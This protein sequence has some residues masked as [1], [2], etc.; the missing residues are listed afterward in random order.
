MKNILLGLM[1]LWP[2]GLEAQQYLQ[3]QTIVEDKSFEYLTTGDLDGDNDEDLIFSTV[4]GHLAWLENTG[5][6][7]FVNLT[8]LKSHLHFYF[9]PKVMDVDN[10]G[11]LDVVVTARDIR[12]I[13]FYL[14]RWMN[15]GRLGWF[16]NLDGDG[17]FGPFIPLTGMESSGFMD[18]SLVDFDVDGNTD[19]LTISNEENK[20]FALLNL[21]GTGDFQKTDLDSIAPQT[22]LMA[23]SDLDKDGDLD[24]LTVAKSTSE[25]IDLYWHEQ[26]D[27]GI[28]SRKIIYSNTIPNNYTSLHIGDYDNN[29]YDDILLSN[30][31]NIYIVYNDSLTFT[32]KSW[33]YL[34]EKLDVATGDFDQDGDL[35]FVSSGILFKNI[36]N[37]REFEQ[38][39]IFPFFPEIFDLVAAD[40]D[41]DGFPELFASDIQTRSLFRLEGSNDD[42]LFAYSG[43]IE[44]ELPKEFV[45][46]DFNGDGDVDIV[47]SQRTGGQS[48]L[49]WKSSDGGNG[50]FNDKEFIDFLPSPFINYFAGDITNDGVTD[51]VFQRSDSD[52]LFYYSYNETTGGFGPKSLML[53][54]PPIFDGGINLADISGD[55]LNDVIVENNGRISIYI[56]I[57]GIGSYASPYHLPAATNDTLNIVD[58]DNDGDLDLVGGNLFWSGWYE[59]KTGIGD[60]AEKELFQITQGNRLILSAD[61][62]GDSFLDLLTYKETLNDRHLNL[63]T[64]SNIDQTLEFDGPFPLGDSL[65]ANNFKVMDVDNDG[66]LDITANF[67]TFYF[68]GYEDRLIDFPMWFENLGQGMTFSPEKRIP[69]V[70]E[71]VE[72]FGFFPL[73]ESRHHYVAED[74]DRDG[75]T[76]LISIGR[77]QI[78]WQKSIPVNSYPIAGKVYLDTTQTCTA[79]D[80]I[81][82]GLGS[83]VIE[84]ERTDGIKYHAL[85]DANGDYLLK[86]DSGDYDINVFLPNSYYYSCFYDSVVTV[87]PSPDT[88]QLSLPVQVGVEC[89]LLSVSINTSNLRPCLP[90]FQTVYYCN[91]GTAVAE[92]VYVRVIFDSLFEVTGSSIPWAYQYENVYI[93]ELDDL[94][95]GD[96]NSFTINSMMDCEAPMG[97]VNCAFARIY[98]DS[99]CNFPTLNWDGSN[100]VVTGECVGDSITFTIRNNGLGDMTVPLDYFIQIVND[101]IVMLRADTF[102]LDAG[103]SI[104]VTVQ[105]KGLALVMQTDQSLNNPAANI[106]TV[107]VPNCSSV[108]TDSLFFILNQFP[109]ANGDPFGDQTCLP[110]TGSFDPNDKQAFPSGFGPN[111]LVE[112]EW[113]IDYLIRFQN[114]GTDTAF[115]VVIQDTLS[116]SLDISTVRPGAA[117]HPYTWDLTGEGALSFTFDDILL[118]DSTTNEPASHGYISFTIEQK[119]DIVP[120]TVFENT[121]AIYFDFNDPIITNTTFHEVIKPVRYEIESLEV[122]GETNWNGHLI[123]SDTLLADT[124]VLIDYDSITLFNVLVHNQ[125]LLTFDTLLHQWEMWNGQFFSMDTSLVDSSLTIFN[126]DSVIVTNVNFIPLTFSELEVMV[127]EGETWNEMI[128]WQ[129]TVLVDT[130]ISTLEDTILITDLMVEQVYDIVIDTM[131]PY[132]QPYFSDTTIVSRFL[133]TNGCDSTVTLHVDVTTGTEDLFKKEATL[134]LRPN[135]TNGHLYCFF[136]NKSPLIHTVSI[137][138]A[139]GK[140]LE[141]WQIYQRPNAADPLEIDLSSFPN[142]VYWIR[143]LSANG[144]WVE[145]VIRSD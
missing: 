1:L 66:D 51:L 126:C 47:F 70:A 62:N 78:T 76:D 52:S 114:T 135:P 49:H 15:N 117:S 130:L 20:L 123:T 115:T 6:G 22:Y 35:D 91:E 74:L 69:F 18:Y 14:P 136:K 17:N 128:F 7:E 129:D 87:E 99:L 29:G 84:A 65:H 32:E 138:S 134:T 75:V 53:T 111:H 2:L 40:F 5:T 81:N 89:P 46:G 122:C 38:I 92:D 37:S 33:Y 4:G 107:M 116:P 102:Y 56:F 13:S 16:E 119:E 110:I 63:S 64:F 101:D 144:A 58:F 68:D 11:D 77:E 36:N 85:T 57:E 120:G 9:P 19:I 140:V 98:P 82:T 3:M 39:D 25:G 26:E 88:I 105:A 73:A 28:F 24:F 41:N 86:V 132:G 95:P 141:N 109:M 142:G 145:K 133:A 96:C 30:I 104:M 143:F 127:C 121:A 125:Y 112:P 61:F 59:N 93:F 97:M 48:S 113:Q 90:A 124:T 94:E 106:P 50:I 80:T 45:T 137:W 34:Y 100:I 12:S 71:P 31:Y 83:W 55:G 42:N 44:S 60:F 21:D 43:R 108:G 54:G 131:M 79:P 27:S 8:T 72:Y 103:E 67:Q 10:D 118:P 23:T 139:N